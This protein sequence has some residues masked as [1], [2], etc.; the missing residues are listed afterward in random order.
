MDRLSFAV[1]DSALGSLLVAASCRGLSHVRFGSD[2]R[3]LEEGLR[4]D[5]PYAALAA[6][7]DPARGFAERI[8]AVIAGAADDLDL[9]LDVPASRFQRRV[10][11]ALQAIPRG[12]TRSYAQVAAA[13][14]CP[15]GARAVARVCATNPVPLVVP[16][17]RVVPR[18]GGVG[19]YLG[20]SWRKRALLEGEVAPWSQGPACVQE[21]RAL[22]LRTR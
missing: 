4:R 13:V 20:G 11:E 12:S 17:H 16:C 8:V 15:R 14:G 18:S 19:G 22:R 5:V 3:A 1:R 21:E 7:A 6:D 10:F 9:P 2:P